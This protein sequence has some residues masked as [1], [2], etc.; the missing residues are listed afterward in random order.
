LAEM[1]WQVQ[2]YGDA[3]QTLIA[4][5]R[6]HEVPLHVFAFRPDHRSVGI[7]RHAAYLLR[8]DTYVALADPHA[9][10]AALE[11]YFAERGI[12]PGGV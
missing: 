10:P 12:T 3:P 6:A 5:C 4:W 8:P 2:V 7:A 11:R 1:I 9:N